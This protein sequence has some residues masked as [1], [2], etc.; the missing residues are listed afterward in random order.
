VAKRAGNA[1]GLAGGLLLIGAAA[2]FVTGAAIGFL[3][4]SLS[5]APPFVTDDVERVAAAMLTALG[6]V[7]LS[8]RFEGRSRP[9]AVV[10]LVAFAFAAM[11]AAIDRIISMQVTTW[12]A[13]RYP[14]RPP[15]PWGR[16]LYPRVHLHRPVRNRS[17]TG[18]WRQRARMGLHDRQRARH[19]SR[20]PGWRRYSAV[21]LLRDRG[22]WCS[23]LAT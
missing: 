4:P 21:R 7:P 11:F 9:W 5:D 14:D 15:L 6:L 22:A 20:S 12:A 10:A 16:F 1:H 18:R 17:V 13:Q 3:A 19:R 8:L 23:H 2:I